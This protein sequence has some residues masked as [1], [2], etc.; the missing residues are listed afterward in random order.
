MSVPP[1]LPL[2]RKTTASE[3]PVMHVPITSDM[4]SWSG[5]SICMNVPSGARI[6]SCIA[7]RKK[8]RAKMAYMVFIMNLNPNTFSATTSSAMFIT[9]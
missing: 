2:L 6:I 5:P 4:K 7:H 1:V 8:A 9:R 3:L